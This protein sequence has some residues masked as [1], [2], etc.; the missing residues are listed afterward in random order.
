LP[1]NF[2]I[3]YQKGILN[4]ADGLLRRLDYLADMEEV[5]QILVSQLLPTLLVRIAHQELEKQS[6]K[7]KMGSTKGISPIIGKNSEDNGLP[8]NM[9]EILTPKFLLNSTG[10]SEVL[11]TVGEVK[12]V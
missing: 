12:E 11:T 8:A 4:P 7:P 10:K 2:Q 9:E 3:F 1:Y 5:N 6:S